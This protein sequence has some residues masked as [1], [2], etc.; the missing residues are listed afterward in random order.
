MNDAA[1]SVHLGRTL[2]GPAA[3]ALALAAMTGFA[4]AAGLD[5]SSIDKSHDTII[6]PR[7]PDD[8]PAGPGAT[9]TAVSRKRVLN[10]HDANLSTFMVEYAPGGSV[11]IP[12]STSYGYVLMHV[13]AGSIK[14]TAWEAGV[15]TYGE[16]QTWVFPAYGNKIATRNTSTDEPARALL[17]LITGDAK[18]PSPDADLKVSGDAQSA[19]ARVP[20]SVSQAPTN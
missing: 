10:L 2:I 3:L 4:G 14:A 11:V 5:E 18:S 19:T 6:Y 15:G 7:F 9:V 16:G 13:L 12:R 17:V 20:D 8:R 1:S